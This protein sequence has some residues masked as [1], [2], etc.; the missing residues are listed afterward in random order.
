MLY[1]IAEKG[2]QYFDENCHNFDLYNVDSTDLKSRLIYLLRPYY[3][4]FDGRYGI[5][6]SK[7]TNDDQHHVDVRDLDNGR[8][9]SETNQKIR[10]GDIQYLNRRG[11]IEEA[12]EDEV[13]LSLLSCIDN[14]EREPLRKLMTQYVKLAFG[15]LSDEEVDHFYQYCRDRVINLVQHLEEGSEYMEGE[16]F[17]RELQK[18][19][20]ET[21]KFAT[22]FL[23]E[24]N[25]K[26]ACD[27]FMQTLHHQSLNLTP[28]H[29][30]KS[31]A[32]LGQDLFEGEYGLDWYGVLDILD[33]LYS[34]TNLCYESL[35]KYSEGFKNEKGWKEVDDIDENFNKDKK[36][37]LERNSEHKR[38]IVKLVN[39]K[40]IIQKPVRHIFRKNVSG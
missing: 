4:D 40:N 12:G 6:Y 11:L 29:R 27:F 16:G 10:D 28:F 36:W 15:K 26:L 34:Q 8:W 30:V 37:I 9:H 7:W 14:I 1:K 13:V 20:Q 3:G 35:I 25:K 32:L 33:F 17:L 5:G 2:K 19:S 38:K 22:I 18:S 39:R 31:Q 24:T 21:N 23:N